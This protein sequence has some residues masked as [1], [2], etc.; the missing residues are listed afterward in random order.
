MYPLPGLKKSCHLHTS[1]IQETVAGA[2][3]LSGGGP[4]LREEG[5]ECKTASLFIT[6][7]AKVAQSGNWRTRGASCPTGLPDLSSRSPAGFA[8]NTG[9]VI[10]HTERMPVQVSRGAC[11]RWH[12]SGQEEQPILQH[13][14][15]LHLLKGC[16]EVKTG[17]FQDRIF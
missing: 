15:A 8:T 11:H 6:T 7:H 16:A 17:I 3:V 9:Q 5:G 2:L 4:S 12:Q 10:P 1:P 13:F 14:S